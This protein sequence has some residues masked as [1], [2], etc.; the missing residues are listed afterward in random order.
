MSAILG[1]TRYA[2]Y[3]DTS[4]KAAKFAAS[5]LLL[6]VAALPAG[7]LVMGLADGRIDASGIIGSVSEIE[8]NG[9]YTEV[10]KE[11]L[12]EG[13]SKL[14]FTEYGI[15]PENASVSIE[16]F[17][18]K[19]MRCEKI[20]ITLYDIGALADFRRIEEYISGSGLGECE[21]YLSIG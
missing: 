11:A 3:P 21:V 17:D 12:I 14:L 6:Y 8:E 13:I 5:I 10:A 18:F 16:G 19:N 9:E 20:K 15:K 7:E 1:F 2:S 4:S